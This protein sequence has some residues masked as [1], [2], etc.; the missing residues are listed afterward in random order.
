MIWQVKDECSNKVYLET[1]SK[2]FASKFANYYNDTHN[3]PFTKIKISYATSLFKR[4]S[5][6]D[7]NKQFAKFGFLTLEPKEY[8]SPFVKNNKHYNR[9]HTLYLKRKHDLVLRLC[10]KYHVW[11]YSKTDGHKMCGFDW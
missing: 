9:M 5:D 8:V 1:T 10:K 6:L 7:I 3:V 2:E 4:Y 11:S